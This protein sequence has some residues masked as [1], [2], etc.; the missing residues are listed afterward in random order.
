M[1]VVANEEPKKFMLAKKK[2]IA[3]S[4]NVFYLL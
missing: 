1:L 4:E 2:I 3:V